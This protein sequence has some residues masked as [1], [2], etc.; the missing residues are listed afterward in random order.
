MY[1]RIR[2][3]H[4]VGAGGIGM[5]GIAELLANQGYQVTGSDL[6]DGPTL[7]RLRAL[8]I[9]IAIG[10][11]AGHV[12]DA[13]V[14]VYSSAVRRSNPELLEAGLTEARRHVGLGQIP[15][16]QGYVGR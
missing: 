6:R 11:D 10:H 7:A 9:R 2:R 3:V 1:R 15:P 14:V 5:C 4:F 16:R 8:G 13:D 12:G